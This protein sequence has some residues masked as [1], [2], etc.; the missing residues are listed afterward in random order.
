LI[1]DYLAVEVS[2][3]KLIEGRLKSPGVDLGLKKG[4]LL[5]GSVKPPVTVPEFK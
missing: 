1:I 3:L 4:G 5:N 2:L